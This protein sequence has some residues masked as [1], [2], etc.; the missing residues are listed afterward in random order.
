[1][2]LI[3]GISGL[4]GI[5]NESLDENVISNHVKAFSRLQPDGT[6]L[7][8]RDSRNHGC[9]FINSACKA[10]N[11]SNRNVVN[12]DLVPTPTIQFLVEKN[13]YAGGIV[14]TA[15]HNPPEWNGI[16]F[17]DSTGLFLDDTQNKKLFNLA[18][19]I[20]SKSQ[21]IDNSKLSTTIINHNDPIEEHI[22][23]TVNLSVI[24]SKSIINR[25][26][27]VVVDAVNG[28]ASYALPILL[29]KLG[30][31]V[32]TINCKP[33]G[34]FPRGA[35]P[36]AH[37]LKQLS[38]SVLKNKADV[39]FA[40]DPDGDRL[41]VV[42][43]KGVP[44]GEEYTLT[45]CTDGLLAKNKIRTPIITNLSTTMAL[46]EVS[47][48]YNNYVER[49][50][51]G[52]INVVKK[53]KEKGSA[54]GGE[55][56][57]GVILAESHLGRDSLVGVSLFLNKMSQTNDSV[58]TIFSKMPQYFMLKD[59]ITL[60]KIDSNEAFEKISKKFS[61]CKKNNQDGLKLLWKDSWVH[62]R[63]SNT[64]PIFRIYSEAKSIEK[65]KNIISGIK[66][67]I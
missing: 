43:E 2:T 63:K 41:A 6:I 46:D 15:S 48:K 44:I 27:K 33:D 17:I 52:E 61:N 54:I 24:D 40:T 59:K 10:L 55:G 42:D 25:K 47:K 5:A 62:I 20:K 34:S 39:G 18:D 13:N 8:G 67:C 1:M 16:K 66:K 53:M 31:K 3:R 29:E 57:G 49:S 9:T 50:L 26:F 37:N 30:C 56:N 38:E 11:H 51:V 7:I 19:S 35:E 4:R 64:E 36:L 32:I 14:I 60:D 28:A 12:C 58:S 21:N 45:I 23:H 65:A 22:A